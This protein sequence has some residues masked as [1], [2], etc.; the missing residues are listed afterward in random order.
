MPL[1]NEYLLLFIDMQYLSTISIWS[2]ILIKQKG[3]EEEEKKKDFSFFLL[4]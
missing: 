4:I 1:L 3:E 2:M